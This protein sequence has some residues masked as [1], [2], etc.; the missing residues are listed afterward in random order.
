[1]AF[2]NGFE[3]RG[4]AETIFIARSQHQQFQEQRPKWNR[5]PQ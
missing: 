4:I 2:K 5:Q 1:L 3:C